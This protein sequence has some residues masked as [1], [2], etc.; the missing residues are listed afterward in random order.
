MASISSITHLMFQQEYWTQKV[1]FLVLL[2]SAL[3]FY[4]SI[5]LRTPLSLFFYPAAPRLLFIYYIKFHSCTIM[6]SLIIIYNLFKEPLFFHV[7][8]LF[9]SASNSSSR[10]IQRCLVSFA[11]CMLLQNVNKWCHLMELCEC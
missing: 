8:G 6:S 1:I 4:T 5:Y 11:D 10:L 7:I 3:I 2:V 9:V